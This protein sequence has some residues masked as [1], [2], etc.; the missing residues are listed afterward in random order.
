MVESG[1]LMTLY[2]KKGKSR[3]IS[4]IKIEKVVCLIFINQKP[5]K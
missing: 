5:M 3:I 2:R 1:S 4:K